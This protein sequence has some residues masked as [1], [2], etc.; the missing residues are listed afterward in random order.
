MRITAAY[1]SAWQRFAATTHDHST[2]EH[3]HL[4]SFCHPVLCAIGAFACLST[5][6]QSGHDRWK[7]QLG[8]QVTLTGEAHNAKLGA[9]LKGE[10]F[11]VWVD[12]PDQ[13]WPDGMYHGPDD[14]DMVVVTGTVTQRA[15]VPAFIPKDGEPM[16]QGVTMPPG[17]DLEEARKRYILVDVTWK[18][19][20]SQR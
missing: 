19:V 2:F 1:A 4:H 8:K 17:T 16:G 15:D 6:A 10:D 5:N 12:L 9:L 13:A 11:Q 7:E 18:P 3:V 20:I 14:G